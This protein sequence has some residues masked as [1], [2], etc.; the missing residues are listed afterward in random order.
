MPAKYVIDSRFRDDQL[1]P[2]TG[3]PAYPRKTAT[4]ETKLRRV[5]KSLQTTLVRTEAALD[6]ALSEFADALDAEDRLAA[7]QARI[8]NMTAQRKRRN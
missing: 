3:L 4:T 8:D 2:N 5:Q 6:R 1:D 7:T